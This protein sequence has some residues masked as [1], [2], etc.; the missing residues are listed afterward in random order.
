MDRRI[1]Y[2]V[3]DISSFR[4]HFISLVRGY[5]F[6]QIEFV[7]GQY[8][9]PPRPHVIP[10]LHH[11][12]PSPGFIITGIEE[13]FLIDVNS[14]A[15]KA[16]PR[17]T[18]SPAAASLNAFYSRQGDIYALVSCHIALFIDFK[19][20]IINTFFLFSIFILDFPRWFPLQAFV[21][22]FCDTA[23]FLAWFL[24]TS[25]SGLGCRYVILYWS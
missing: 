4:R 13:D 3:D 11:W 16:S 7:I 5:A 23:S 12:P 8:R 9:S 17:N 18:A 1:D 25:H 20:R 2:W 10:L 19:P 22:Y 24:H 15:K 21:Y 6:R 14:A